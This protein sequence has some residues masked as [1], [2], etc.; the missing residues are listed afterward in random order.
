MSEQVKRQG[1]TTREAVET[2]SAAE[3]RAV[4]IHRC[5]LAGERGGKVSFNEALDDWTSNCAVQW[6][7]ERLADYLVRQRAEILKHKWIESEKAHRDLGK[8]AVMD[9]IKHHAESW[10]RWY[11]THGMDDDFDRESRAGRR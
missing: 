4:E 5:R 6:R 9:W 7:Q 10:R 2:L 11:D 8:E 1:G 3:Q